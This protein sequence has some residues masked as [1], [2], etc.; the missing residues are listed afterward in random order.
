MTDDA[1][2]NLPELRDI[3]LPVDGVSVFPLANGWW[4]LLFTLIAI[5]VIYKIMVFIKRTSAKLYARYLLRTIKQ[6]TS[7]HAAVKIS[8]ILRR[9]CIRK[10]PQAVALCGDEWINFLNSKTK[11]KINGKTAELLK[12]APYISETKQEYTTQQMTELKQFAYH[13]TGDNL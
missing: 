1:I 6:D 11:H 13:W 5:A 10:Y 7:L 4:V 2:I 3:H 9:I 8:E 12:N